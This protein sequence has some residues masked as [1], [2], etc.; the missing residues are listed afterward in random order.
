M[1]LIVNPTYN[2]KVILEVANSVL[3]AKKEHADDV[4]TRICWTD[5]N[6]NSCFEYVADVTRSQAL[7]YAWSI[8][9]KQA[10]DAF[11]KALNTVGIC[12]EVLKEKKVKETIKDVVT[13]DDFKKIVYDLAA[14][15]ISNKVWW[16]LATEANIDDKVKRYGYGRLA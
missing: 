12:A 16:Q 3:K 5:K 14:L 13:I 2:K 15:K 4:I 8:A 6:G 11:S 10:T 9:R 7:Q 1:F